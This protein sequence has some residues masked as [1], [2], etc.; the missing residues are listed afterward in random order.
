MEYRHIRIEDRGD[1]LVAHCL[2]HKYVSDMDVEGVARELFDACNVA[3][4]E[5]KNVVFDLGGVQLL[6]SSMLGKLITINKRL[7]QSGLSFRIH[8]MSSDLSDLLGLTNLRGFR[9]VSDD[10]IPA[11]FP[12][13]VRHEHQRTK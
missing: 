4:T 12:R 2:Q 1:E 8:N 7:R 6:S 13:T 9:D 3:I 5:T 10:P 11:D